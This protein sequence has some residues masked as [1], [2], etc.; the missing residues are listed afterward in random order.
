MDPGLATALEVGTD[1]FFGIHLV[2]KFLVL[3]LLAEIPFVPF[4]NMRV[5]D[6]SVW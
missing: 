1:S 4:Y 2:F 6:H 5:C 3:L